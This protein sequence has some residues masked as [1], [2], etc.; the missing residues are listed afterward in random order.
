MEGAVNLGNP[1]SGVQE[2]YKVEELCVWVP[3]RKEAW[4]KGK[5]REPNAWILRALQLTFSFHIFRG[6]RFPS[7][8]QPLRPLP[9]GNS[10]LLVMPGAMEL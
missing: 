10:H 6:E 1:T 3:G 2:K 4:G 8:G 5:G 7:D 9:S